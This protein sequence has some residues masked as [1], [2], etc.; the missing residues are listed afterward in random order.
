MGF[1]LVWVSEVE[2]TINSSFS[3]LA[4]QVSNHLDKVVARR[5]IEIHPDD[6]CYCIAQCKC[7]VSELHNVDSPCVTVNKIMMIKGG[8][9]PSR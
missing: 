4:V 9:N 7:R 2:L 3:V 8:Q 6:D 1:W 5:M